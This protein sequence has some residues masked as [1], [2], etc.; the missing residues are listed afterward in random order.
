MYKKKCSVESIPVVT[1]L[2]HLD[3]PD[4]PSNVHGTIVHGDFEDT[5]ENIKDASGGVERYNLQL[6]SEFMERVA[7]LNDEGTRMYIKSFLPGKNTGYCKGSELK[8]LF[9][10]FLLTTGV[11]GCHL[12][13][14]YL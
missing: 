3:Y 13:W 4:T 7:V 12:V 9:F 14:F 5:P 1:G 8:A 2:I 6:K 11:L 10:K